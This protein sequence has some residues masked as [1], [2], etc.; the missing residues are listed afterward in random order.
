[1]IGLVREVANDP[2]EVAQAHWPEAT[3]IGDVR[4][5]NQ[6]VLDGIV[7]KR[8]QALVWMVGSIPHGTGQSLTESDREYFQLAADV[9]AWIKQKTPRCLIIPST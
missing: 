3:S 9:H 2:L 4:L 7:S 6:Q 1:M 5:L 8:S